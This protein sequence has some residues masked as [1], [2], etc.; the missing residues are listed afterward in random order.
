ALGSTTAFAYSTWAFLSG[1][2]GH[3]YFMEAAAIITLISIGH[4]VE[5]RVGARASDALRQL[6]QLAPAVASRREA[7]GSE[8][9]V[10]LGELRPGDLVV[11]KPG[12]RVPTDGEVVEGA[13]AVDES[14]LTGES[15]PVD[16]AP[17]AKLY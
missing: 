16:K 10:P 5:A 14:M 2:G 15:L 11:L 6:M 7:D 3:L 1:H 9:Q 8:R 13:S 12:D 17:G 4:W